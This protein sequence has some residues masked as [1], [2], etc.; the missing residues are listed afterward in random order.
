MINSGILFVGIK[1]LRS[2][3]KLSRNHRMGK[4]K[5]L[6]DCTFCTSL[7]NFC[8]RV[9]LASQVDFLANGRNWPKVEESQFQCCLH[10]IRKNQLRQEQG[11]PDLLKIFGIQRQAKIT[12]FAEEAGVFEDICFEIRRI[13]NENSFGMLDRR[14]SYRT[15]PV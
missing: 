6:F 10:S 5:R 7:L 12:V 13:R 11:Q 2:L 4:C 14:T 9:F 3:I 15:K 1:R 8:S